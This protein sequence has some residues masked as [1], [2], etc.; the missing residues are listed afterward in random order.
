MR[1]T[2]NSPRVLL[3]RDYYYNAMLQAYYFQFS[4][5]LIATVLDFSRNSKL[6]LLSIL[7]ESYCNLWG[8]GKVVLMVFSFQFSSSLI[9][10]YFVGYWLLCPG[11][12]SILLESYCNGYPKE[13]NHRLAK[14]S[15]LLES[16]C[17]PEKKPSATFLSITFNSPRVL[18]QR[19]CYLLLCPGG[20]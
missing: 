17:N 16:Y 5:S 19:G 14:L 12:L 9:A 13:R 10:T 2:F 1:T 6:T 15:I 7:L 11:P 8:L 18:L 20:V 3:Q 4:S